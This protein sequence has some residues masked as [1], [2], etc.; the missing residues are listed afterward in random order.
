MTQYL[1]VSRKYLI[2]TELKLIRNF[3]SCFP[4]L[5]QLTLTY[6]LP[7][8]LLGHHWVLLCSELCICPWPCTSNLD[9][10]RSPSS[11]CSSLILL[12][13]PTQS[14]IFHFLTFTYYWSIL[15][16]F[17]LIIL[18]NITHLSGLRSFVASSGKS[19]LKDKPWKI[20]LDILLFCFVSLYHCILTLSWT[21]HTEWHLITCLSLQLSF[22][23]END[24]YILFVTTPPVL[25]EKSV[26]KWI[27]L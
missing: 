1:V 24:G 14:N 23:N 20:K 15:I 18:T 9:V 8:W 11:L 17:S 16:L 12:N 27:H 2:Y 10:P 25:N 26:N 4:S 7:P 19:T 6:F 21:Y 22:I 5:Q 13:M 3:F